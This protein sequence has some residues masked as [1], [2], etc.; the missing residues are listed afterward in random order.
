[1]RYIVKRY[2]HSLKGKIIANIDAKSLLLS[3]KEYIA[4]PKMKGL[5]A[6]LV[7]ANASA[8]CFTLYVDTGS[9]REWR[10]GMKEF[11]IEPGYFFEVAY[12][13]SET[14]CI[15]CSKSMFRIEKTSEGE[16]CLS[17]KG[18]YAIPLY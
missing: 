1:M 11:E 14:P 3:Q 9:E 18:W 17:I 10:S 6:A 5:L 13:T 2:G 7:I 16:G 15:P 12:L 8:S 4:P